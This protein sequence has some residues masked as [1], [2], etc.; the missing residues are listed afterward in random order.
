MNKLTFF[1]TN[2]DC[3]ACIKLSTMALK[4]IPGVQNI[5]IDIKTGKTDVESESPLVWDEV[6]AKLSEVGKTAKQI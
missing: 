6:I 1:I 5:D 3:E 2:L 4:K